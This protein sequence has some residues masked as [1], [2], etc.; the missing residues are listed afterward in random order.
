MTSFLKS[1]LVMGKGKS[2]CLVK[3]TRSSQGRGS[4]GF[5]L[6]LASLSGITCIWTK[7]GLIRS[8]FGEVH[9]WLSLD[10]SLMLLQLVSG[11]IFN[12]CGWCFSLS[13]VS[14]NPTGLG[15]NVS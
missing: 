6:S 10:G 5:L 8:I 3:V 11:G 15:R 9:W 2:G 7:N 4:G 1:S 12:F 14:L 13:S